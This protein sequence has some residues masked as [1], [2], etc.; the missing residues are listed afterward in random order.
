MRTEKREKRLLERRKTRKEENY[1][2]RCGQKQEKEKK[3]I[4]PVVARKIKRKTDQGK[5]EREHRRERKNVVECLTATGL[6]Q[7]Q[8]CYE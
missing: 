6:L 5:G 7:K 8:H 1:L 2:C 4:M 3:K